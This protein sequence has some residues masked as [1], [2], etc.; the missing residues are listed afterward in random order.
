MNSKR[1]SHEVVRRGIDCEA[2]ALETRNSEIVKAR[3]TSAAVCRYLA[4]QSVEEFLE[5]LF[6]LLALI[7]CV[8]AAG[9]VGILL[10]NAIGG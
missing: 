8:A 1:I 2:H 9:L 3:R 7:Y 4:S 5:E 6:A 10:G